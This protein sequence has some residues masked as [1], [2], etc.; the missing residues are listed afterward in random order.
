MVRFN[1]YNTKGFEYNQFLNR[2]SWILKFHSDR[3][4][5]Y[6]ENGEINIKYKP[7]NH[8]KI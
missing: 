7:L 3:F 6:C 5:L 1:I 8:D 2:L 4:E